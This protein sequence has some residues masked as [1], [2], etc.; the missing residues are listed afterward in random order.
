LHCHTADDTSRR[1]HEEFRVCR[2]AHLNGSR[3]AGLEQGVAGTAPGS[4]NIS[5]NGV[6]ESPRVNRLDLGS[7]NDLHD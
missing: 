1:R 4:A 3:H 6:A 5:Y 7:Y 2:R